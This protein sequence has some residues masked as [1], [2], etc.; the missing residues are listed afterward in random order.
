[1]LGST[2]AKSWLCF[3]SF[4]DRFVDSKGPLGFVFENLPATRVRVQVIL[5]LVA[6][7][8]VAAFTSI[9][10]IPREH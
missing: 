3:V 5:R 7:P 6:K 1:L 4:F 10:P 8:K 9:Q 2:C